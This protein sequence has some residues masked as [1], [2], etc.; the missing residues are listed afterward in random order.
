MA[1]RSIGTRDKA[2]ADT[3]HNERENMNASKLT[4]EQ[5]NYICQDFIE[6]QLARAKSMRAKSEEGSLYA[7]VCDEQ[8]KKIADIFVSVG[9]WQARKGN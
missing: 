9:Y 7:N 2:K 1:C 4:A 6:P 3:Q 8:I 5:I